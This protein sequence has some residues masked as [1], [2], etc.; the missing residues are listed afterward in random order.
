V[1][2]GSLCS[3]G[4]DVVS[5]WEGTMMKTDAEDGRV[6]REGWRKM[7]RKTERQRQQLTPRMDLD[8]PRRQHVAYHYCVPCVSV[9]MVSIPVHLAVALDHSCR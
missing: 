7:E 5:C 6:E 2:G 3:A 4:F 9:W 8:R 1:L